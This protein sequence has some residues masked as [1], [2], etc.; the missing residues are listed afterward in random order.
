MQLE[1]LF[2]ISSGIYFKAIKY[3]I[4]IKKEKNI[5]PYLFRKRSTNALYRSKGSCF[6]DKKEI[7]KKLDNNYGTFNGHK[8]AKLNCLENKIEK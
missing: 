6:V 2:L 1:F 8:I 4:G 5:Q 3:L 7:S